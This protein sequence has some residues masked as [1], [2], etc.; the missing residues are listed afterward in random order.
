MFSE[1]NG[2]TCDTEENNYFRY[3]KTT[4]ASIRRINPLINILSFLYRY[5]S[6]NRFYLKKTI[7]L[8]FRN[9]NLIVVCFHA[10]ITFK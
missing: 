2:M 6:I 9:I 3:S 10:T 5:S 4:I 8:I 7:V 1:W